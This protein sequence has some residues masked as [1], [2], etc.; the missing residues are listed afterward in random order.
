MLLSAMTNQR[1]FIIILLVLVVERLAQ[2]VF[3]YNFSLALPLLV[4]LAFFA[5]R[6]KTMPWS[7]FIGGVL[8]D[9]SSGLPFG[10]I[11]LAVFTV[12]L[13]II[14]SQK[15]INFFNSLPAFLFAAVIFSVITWTMTIWLSSSSFN[16]FFSSAAVIGIETILISLILNFLSGKPGFQQI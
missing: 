15:K 7:L 8:F 5:T 9:L 4:S 1:I 13:L 2:S 11:T 3:F 16:V 14:S 10:V 12:Y 6:L